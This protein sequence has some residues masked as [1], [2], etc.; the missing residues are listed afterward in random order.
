M[1]LGEAWQ[2][3]ETRSRFTYNKTANDLSVD[4]TQSV[5]M[6]C[7]LVGSAGYRCQTL[8]HTARLGVSDI[9]AVVAKGGRSAIGEVIYEIWLHFEEKVISM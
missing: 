6:F 3:G 9:A 5:D 2:A 4:S 8:H 7:D 1:N